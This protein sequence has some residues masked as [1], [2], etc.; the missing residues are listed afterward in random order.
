MKFD[1]GSLDSAF[2]ADWPV[3]VQVPLD[4]GKSEEQTFQ[5]R[6]RLVD[7]E[8]LAQLGDGVEAQKKALRKVVVGFGKGEAETF[9]AETLE[10]MLAR[11][12]V[13]SGLNRAYGQF[14]LG[15]P[16]KNS[17]TPAA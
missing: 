8:E 15:I 7:D 6:F 14:V 13:R 16:A 2:E 3:T 1:F 5:V 17:E 12:Y 9:S 4:G 10:K 11:A